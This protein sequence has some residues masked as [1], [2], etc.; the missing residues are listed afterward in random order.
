M[1]IWI[2]RPLVGGHFWITF[3]WTLGTFSVFLH[4]CFACKPIR[5]PKKRKK[6]LCSATGKRCG[7]IL[8]SFMFNFIHWGKNENRKGVIKSNSTL[9]F[10]YLHIF[11]GVWFIIFEFWIQCLKRECVYFH[12]CSAVC[13]EKL[14]GDFPF[15]C[16]FSF[17]FHQCR[18]LYFLVFTLCG[19]FL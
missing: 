3:L 5:Y 9:L 1:R 7:N 8:C 16:Y 18:L 19:C 4:W 2:W 12:V 13:L 10:I 15:Y 14:K 11:Y 17:N 6:K